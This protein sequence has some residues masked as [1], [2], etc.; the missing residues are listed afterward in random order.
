MHSA[1]CGKLSVFDSVKHQLFSVAVKSGR[2]CIIRPFFIEYSSPLAYSPVFGEFPW[3]ISQMIL[4]AEIFGGSRCV[5]AAFFHDD[6]L[7]QCF[8]WS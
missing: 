7:V 6:I 1:D 5:S 4:N 8:R 2:S 3:E